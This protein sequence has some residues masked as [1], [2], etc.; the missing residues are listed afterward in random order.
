LFIVVR[1]DLPPGLQTAQ[2]VHAAFLFASEHPEA[3][4]KWHEE[5]NFVVVLTITNEASL[6][7]RYRKLPSHCARAMVV[8]PDLGDECTAFAVLGADAGR[9]L[10]DLPLALKEVAMV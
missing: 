1:K 2:A 5:S 7:N 6:R 3:M 8:E 9:M 4:A 10:S